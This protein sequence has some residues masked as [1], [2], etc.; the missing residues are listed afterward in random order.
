V[1]P[2]G[3]ALSVA[4]KENRMEDKMKAAD[5]KIMNSMPVIFWAKNED[6]VYIFGNDTINEFGGGV[7]GKTDHELP[8]ADT[9]DGLVAHDKK[10]LAAGKPG[11]MHEFVHKSSKGEATIN[12]CKWPGELDGVRC[13]FGISFII[14][15]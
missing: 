9:A 5:L 14:E 6:G 15:D 3:S 4:P 8:W 10:V 11:Y 13:T 7:V 12:V 2:S 1:S